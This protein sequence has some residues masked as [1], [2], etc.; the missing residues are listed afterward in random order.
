MKNK[1]TGDGDVTM[2]L[3]LVRD[4]AVGWRV[5][6]CVSENGTLMVTTWCCWWRSSS[7]SPCRCSGTWVSVC[8]C[9]PGGLLWFSNQSNKSLKIE[10]T[11]NR[12]LMSVLLPFPVQVTLVTLV[13]FPCSAWCS[14][15]LWWVT[16]HFLIL[17]KAHTHFLHVGQRV[18]GEF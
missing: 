15:W 10:I 9:V 6:C 2:P 12:L 16:R 7:S 17:H 3:L 18:S 4:R 1:L 8:V 14:S 5:V 11:Y 13:V